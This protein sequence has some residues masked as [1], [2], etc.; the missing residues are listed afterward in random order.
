VRLPRPQ[1][2][3]VAQLHRNPHSTGG[4]P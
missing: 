2:A 1:A 4:S 3:T